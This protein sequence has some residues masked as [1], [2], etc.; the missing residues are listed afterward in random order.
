MNTLMA[1]SVCKGMGGPVAALG[2][3]THALGDTLVLRE[4][5]RQRQRHKTDTAVDGDAQTPA[6]KNVY[7]LEGFPPL[8]HTPGQ[9]RLHVSSQKHVAHPQTGWVCML[10]HP[11]T[12]A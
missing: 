4:R 9:K 7:P 10:P 5:Q 8:R 3:A 6:K 1:L 11:T 12:C 2:V